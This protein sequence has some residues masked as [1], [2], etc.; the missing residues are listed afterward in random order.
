MLLHKIRPCC[1]R[2]VIAGS[3]TFK[4]AWISLSRRKHAWFWAVVAS[5]KTPWNTSKMNKYLTF[6][7][8]YTVDHGATAARENILTSW[9]F[10]IF[11]NVKISLKQPFIIQLYL[12]VKVSYFRGGGFLFFRGKRALQ[13]Q[14]PLQDL[15]HGQW[16]ISQDW[17]HHHPGCPQHSHHL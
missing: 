8:T 11:G 15:H 1:H 7:L 4:T 16:D 12:L 5:Y 6:M 3:W 13:L 14:P 17:T 2:Y 10:C 9:I